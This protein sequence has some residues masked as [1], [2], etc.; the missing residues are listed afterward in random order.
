MIIEVECPLCS[1]HLDEVE[2]PPLKA[3]AER[4][5]DAPG[6]ENH[7]KYAFCACCAET[8]RIDPQG[9]RGATRGGTK[10]QGACGV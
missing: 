8:F 1:N 5:G 10:I 3:K 2:K 9:A 7:D 6:D 4:L